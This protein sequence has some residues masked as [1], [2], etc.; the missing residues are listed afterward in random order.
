MRTRRS[1]E[2]EL[3]E[4]HEQMSELTMQNQSLAATRR[5]LDQEADNL[6]QDSDDIR[7]IYI[8]LHSFILYIDYDVTRMKAFSAHLC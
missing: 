6:R 2:Q 7:G 4:C 3:A 1:A 8:G 5:K